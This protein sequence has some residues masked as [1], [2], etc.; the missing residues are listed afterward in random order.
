M[1]RFTCSCETSAGRCSSALRAHKKLRHKKLR[2]HKN[3]RPVIGSSKLSCLSQ[4][5][6]QDN[7]PLFADKETEHKGRKNTFVHSHTN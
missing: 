2:L 3:I 4:T 6:K 1:S 7:A 5:H